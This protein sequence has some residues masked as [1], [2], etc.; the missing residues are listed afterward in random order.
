MSKEW[1]SI[2]STLHL[3]SSK[4]TNNWRNSNTKQ[5]DDGI[6]FTAS[7]SVLFRSSYSYKSLRANKSIQK[8]ICLCSFVQFTSLGY[9]LIDWTRPLNWLFRAG[10]WLPKTTNNWSGSIRLLIRS[11][12][13]TKQ[14]NPTLPICI[15]IL[16]CSIMHAA[17]MPNVAAGRKV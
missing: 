2:A 11:T 12:L 5:S 13:E 4:P 14:T 16:W 8:N 17:R 6:S 3:P 1:D 9:C 15:I 7:Q 10:W